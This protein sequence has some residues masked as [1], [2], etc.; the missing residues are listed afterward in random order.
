MFQGSVAT[1]PKKM[2]PQKPESDVKKPE[3]SQPAPPAPPAAATPTTGQRLATATTQNQN[4]NLPAKQEET[5][6][7]TVNVLNKKSQQPPPLN[8]LDRLSVRNPEETFQHLIF[9]NTVVV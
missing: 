8:K 2:T 5:T 4:L 7:K 9:K 1:Q 3:T 6:T